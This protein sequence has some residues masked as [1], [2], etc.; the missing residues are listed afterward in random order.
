MHVEFDRD[1]LASALMSGLDLN[2]CEKTDLDAIILNP[3]QELE[4]ELDEE[5]ATLNV[6]A[7]GGEYKIGPLNV[8]VVLG[9]LVLLNIIDSPFITGDLKEGDELT[10]EEVA[11]TL[12][13][14]CLGK[15]ALDPVMEVQQRISDLFLL[16][17]VAKGNPD[18]VE[19]IIKKAEAISNGRIIFA[20]KAIDYYNEHF[21]GEDFQEIVNSMMV[22]ILDINKSLENLPQNVG[23]S[24]KKKSEK[25]N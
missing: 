14:L 15:D 9:N 18:M 22:M 17:T 6:T 21:L 23:K 10:F 19:A 4:E 20:K 12:Y 11:K 13:V 24:K 2:D 1:K 8:S 25:K 3:E 16:K 5:E 7:I